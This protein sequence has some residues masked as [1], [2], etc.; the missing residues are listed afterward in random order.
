MRRSAAVTAMALG[1]TGGAVAAAVPGQDRHAPAGGLPVDRPL[2]RHDR[3]PDG[4]FDPG[5]SHF[6]VDRGSVRLAVRA[7]GNPGWAVRTF[8]G[9]RRAIKQPARTLDRPAWR[10]HVGCADVVRTYRGMQG[11]LYPDGRFRPV[12]PGASD[13]TGECASTRRALANTEMITAVAPDRRGEWM[14]GE[15]VL[16]GVAPAGARSAVVEGLRGGRRPVSIGPQGAFLLA[17]GTIDP[18]RGMRIVFRLGGNRRLRQRVSRSAREVR[19]LRGPLPGTDRLEAVTP[20]PAGGPARGILVARRG[21]GGVCIG[22]VA[23]RLGSRFGLVDTGL[24]IMSEALLRR[25]DCRRR[26]VTPTP[27]LP[28]VTSIGWGGG[29]SVED[30]QWVRR[31][32]IERRLQRGSATVLAFCHPDVEQVTIRTSRDLRTLVPSPRAHA[33]LAIYDGELAGDV[34]ITARL[35]DGSIWTDHLSF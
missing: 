20:D 33:I 25:S 35:R 21:D 5:V 19:S 22:G 6:V 1:L 10:M 4:R 14:P 29:V 7:P 12:D 34:V 17:L 11:W 18:P 13:R 8:T 3:L 28:V 27:R 32:R 2:A 16:W 23:E 26:G 15:S 9:E 24:G 30:D 31:A